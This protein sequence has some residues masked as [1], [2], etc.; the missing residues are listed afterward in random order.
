MFKSISV[1]VPAGTQANAPVQETVKLCKGTIKSVVFRPA[2]GPQWELYAKVVYRETAIIPF[3]ETQWIPLEQY[4]VEAQ[5]NWN[6]WDGT[7][8]IE[9]LGCSPEARF[10]HTFIVEIEVEEGM[11]EVEAILDLISRG[12]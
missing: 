1:T 10:N 9:I 12:F 4:P 7:Y 11:T 5:P 6:R 8:D 2:I 3:D